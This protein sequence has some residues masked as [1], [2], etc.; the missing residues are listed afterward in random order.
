MHTVR[1][2]GRRST[3]NLP[4]DHFIPFAPLDD[5][6]ALLQESFHFFGR[7]CGYSAKYSQSP[8]CINEIAFDV[9]DATTT[10]RGATEAA[11]AINPWVI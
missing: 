3:V 10:G 11:T 6:P 5:A 9:A 8:L 2:I 1:H 7:Q 4:L